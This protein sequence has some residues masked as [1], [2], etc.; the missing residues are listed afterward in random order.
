MSVIL[1]LNMGH[2]GS[3]A[4]VRDGKL[5]AA[6]SRERLSRKKKQSGVSVEMID[7]VLSIANAKMED[8]DC[9]AFAVYDY[10]PDNE[11]KVFTE[12]G[13]QE[14]TRHL[15]DMPFRRVY[16]PYQVRI[17]ES[18]MRPAH[19]VHHHLSHCASAYY[20]SRFDQAACF[21][22]DASMS[23]PEACSLFAYGQGMKLHPFYCPG[24]MIGNAYSIF[25]QKLGLGSGLFKAGT[26]MGLAAYATPSAKARNRAAF[27]TQPYYSRPFMPDDL[28]F[29]DFMWSDLSERAPHAPFPANEKDSKDAMEVA[30][31]IQH[32]FEEAIVEYAGRLYEETRAF[33]GGNICL[34][35]GSFLNCNA[36]TAVRTRTPFRRVHLFPAAGDDGTGVGAALWIAHHVQEHERVCYT[37]GETAY[38]GKSYPTPASFDGERLNL[39][40][41]AEAISEGS[42][43]AWYQGGAEFGPRALGHRSLLADP[44]RHD[45]RD[46][47]NFEVKRREWFRPL[48][49]SVLAEDAPDW[50]DCNGD[51]P[52]MLYTS[53][54]LRPN[55]IPAVT[56]VDGSARQ[57]T[58][59]KQDN[60]LFH[61]LISNFRDVTG[62]PMLLNTSLNVNGQP[63]VETPDDA[64]RFFQT[65]AADILVLNDRMVRRQ[66]IA[67]AD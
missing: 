2:D 57:Q 12:D 38:L 67:P 46:I 60:P 17:G 18:F 44:R 8:I 11:V 32:I 58:V 37:A 30:A 25:T 33:N 13:T 26:T 29:I 24:L 51:S 54:V 55:D 4:V 36:N 27:Y 45:M 61:E 19:F 52:F 48:A 63:L 10:D 28:T 39:R 66:R 15:Y 42:I 23:R 22:L 40:V 62:V 56:H 16:M 14:I 9:I 49:P 41:V 20:T 31:S 34:S 3:A 7:Y 1:G 59:T 65:H 43:V 21:S 35:G 50:F 53:R 5:V 47:I 64:T 6:L